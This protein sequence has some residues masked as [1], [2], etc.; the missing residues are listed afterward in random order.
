MILDGKLGGAFSTAI[1][2]VLPFNEIVRGKG[3]IFLFITFIV[4]GRPFFSRRR[5]E[6]ELDSFGVTNSIFNVR[7]DALNRK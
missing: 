3:R 6:G 4:P 2:V 5:E 1:V 7:S